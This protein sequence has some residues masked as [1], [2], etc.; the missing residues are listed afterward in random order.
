MLVKAAGTDARPKDERSNL[1]TL[2]SDKFQR[3]PY[4]LIVFGSS[5]LL[6]E[7]ADGKSLQT[8]FRLFQKIFVFLTIAGLE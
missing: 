3:F 4:R 6:R 1:E 2:I 8:V 5:I 7:R